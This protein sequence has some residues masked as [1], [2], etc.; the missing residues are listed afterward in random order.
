MQTSYSCRE[1]RSNKFSILCTFFVAQ[2]GESTDGQY[3]Q[4][5][6]LILRRD[7]FAT[8]PAIQ[9]RSLIYV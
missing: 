9:R 5:G 2:T 7:K 6:L 4:C 3:P 8:I 1:K